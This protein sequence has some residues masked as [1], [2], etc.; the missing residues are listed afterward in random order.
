MVKLLHYKSNVSHPTQKLV[1]GGSSCRDFWDKQVFYVLF[2]R[3]TY[4]HVTDGS[5]FSCAGVGL[6]T[7]MLPGYPKLHPLAPA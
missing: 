1:D 7:V 4:V 3:P 5:T 2:V 6:V